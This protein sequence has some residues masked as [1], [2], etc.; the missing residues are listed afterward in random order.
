MAF[1]KRQRRIDALSKQLAVVLVFVAFIHAQLLS[2]WAHVFPI[3]VGTERNITETRDHLCALLFI[4]IEAVPIVKDDHRWAPRPGVVE[5]KI[6][7]HLVLSVHVRRRDLDDVG[8][9]ASEGKEEECEH[10]CSHFLYIT[11]PGVGKWFCRTIAAPIMDTRSR[12][13]GCLLGGAVGDALGAPVEFMQHDQIK[14]RYGDDG[15]RDFARAYGRTGAITDDTQMTLFTA[16]GV[17]R[18]IVRG[19]LK[20]ICDPYGVV[21]RAYLRWYITQGEIPPKDFRA[22]GWLITQKGLYKRR[23]PGNSVMSALSE[24]G[25]HPDDPPGND[26]M[27]C[28]GVMRVAPVGLL[29]L[30]PFRF[31]CRTA[32]ITHG[33]PLGQVPAGCMAVLIRA[34]I[35]GA[36]IEDA[37]NKAKEFARS[38]KEQTDHIDRALSLAQSDATAVK[39]IH[40]LGCGWTA[41][42][43]LAIAI[44]A[45]LRAESLEEAVLMAV[46]HDGDSDS[47]GSIAG[48]IMGALH[49]VEAIPA[50]WIESL[51]L[52]DLIE[53][54]A[55]DLHAWSDAPPS[56]EE[57]AKDWWVRYPGS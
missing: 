19:T 7:F 36:E 11:T 27:G 35:E 21:R 33:H 34:I 18:A 38:Y 6:A 26:S 10:D 16:E 50:R 2:L 9:G 44:F 54:V 8:R 55:L 43:A 25:F 53:Q 29:M 5:D 17:I 57:I 48:Q 41:P 4:L 49:G 45:C 20:G 46:N 47:T 32:A 12:F 23:A 3:H 24:G 30:R 52:R 31:G 51:E 15:I 1:D 39:A 37:I 13:V 22:D 28:G 56:E 40:S 14:K 42:D